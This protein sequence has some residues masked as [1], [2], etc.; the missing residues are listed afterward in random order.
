MDERSHSVLGLVVAKKTG[1]K[2]LKKKG[3]RAQKVTL[4]DG[5]EV[6]NHERHEFSTATKVLL[7]KMAG[8]ICS[9][10]ACKKFTVGANLDF[11]NQASLGQAAHICS[12][13]PGR[14]AARY[15]PDQSKEERQSAENG[16]WLC[17]NHATLID[18]DERDYSVETLKAWKQ[19]ACSR[20]RSLVGKRSI[21]PTEQQLAI[22]TAVGRH[23]AYSITHQS[24]PLITESLT[25]YQSSWA[26]LDDRFDVST[27]ASADVIRL[28]IAA[29]EGVNAKIAIN[30]V[31][32]SPGEIQR[33]IEVL[34][35]TGESFYVSSGEFLFEGSALFEALNEYNYNIRLEVGARE[36]FAEAAVYL[37]AKDKEFHLAQCESRAKGGTEFLSFAGSALNGLISFSFSVDLRSQSAKLSYQCSIESWKNQALNDVQNYSRMMKALSFMNENEKVSFKVELEVANRTLTLPPGARAEYTEVIDFLCHNLR[38][39]KAA[40]ELSELVP[41]SLSIKALEFS[42]DNIESAELYVRANRGTVHKNFNYGD[43]MFIAN[44]SDLPACYAN[45]LMSGVEIAPMALDDD[46]NVVLEFFG[47][48]V[49]CP[50]M[51]H[52]WDNFYASLFFMVDGPFRGYAHVSFY[53]EQGAVMSHALLGKIFKSVERQA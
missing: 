24:G 33:K 35:K 36:R 32:R 26:A 19:E 5:R 25:A 15:D 21:T 6:D 46:C 50:K 34:N 1:M 4:P 47:N 42:E 7:M 9:N 37:V 18:A 31:E 20:S 27:S 41:E 14:G 10:P 44:V 23:K 30:F 13:A 52:V 49:E 43:V 53:A 48:S 11:N 28:V 2:T 39:L 16:I 12:A 51:Q 8:G 22:A 38:A 3:S 29:K 17:A 40:V 45:P